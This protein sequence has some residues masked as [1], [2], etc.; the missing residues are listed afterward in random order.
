M[1][2][3]VDDR[4][5]TRAH[6]VFDVLYLKK[7]RII[8]MEQHIDRLYNS[9]KSVNIVPPFDK[10]RAREV[11]VD[12]VEQIV[13]HHL[14]KDQTKKTSDLVLHDS[15]GIRMTISS[16]FGDLSVA[17]L[18]IIVTPRTNSQFFTSSSSSLIFP[19]KKKRK[20]S[21]NS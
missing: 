17:S 19:T 4:T 12:V 14:R 6:G 11:L 9:A 16:G 21:T 2:L 3:P 10:E 20:V 1:L 18:V 7:K 8:N 13:D 5:A 15:L